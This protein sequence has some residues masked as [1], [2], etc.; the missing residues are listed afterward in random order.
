MEKEINQ[1]K[2]SSS[3]F[4]PVSSK[5]TDL[6]NVYVVGYSDNQG[7]GDN[8]KIA[9][10]DLLSV[11]EDN[12]EINNIEPNIH[13]KLEI[14]DGVAIITSQTLNGLYPRDFILTKCLI[15]TNN[16][17]YFEYVPEIEYSATL[18]PEGQIKVIFFDE[19]HKLPYFKYNF[20]V[21]LLLTKKK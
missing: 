2:F 20:Y 9:I 12:I 15:S 8:I 11:T 1:V 13:G 6:K 21:R 10:P 16:S 7:E 19:N 5:D 14:I 18:G 4:R 17:T 3:T